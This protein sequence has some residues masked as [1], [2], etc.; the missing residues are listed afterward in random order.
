MKEAT[1][2]D[3]LKALHTLWLRGGLS[4]SAIKIL[5]KNQCGV[6]LTLIVD[7]KIMAESE[8]GTTK[9]RIGK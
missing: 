2:F 1:E 8:D 4:S 9:Y 3:I 7:D 5:L 6:I